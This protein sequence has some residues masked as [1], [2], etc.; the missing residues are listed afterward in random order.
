MWIEVEKDAMAPKPQYFMDLKFYT[1]DMYYLYIKYN[2][3]KLK[4][5][6]IIIILKLFIFNLK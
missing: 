2:K 6:Q 1:Q 4:N 3:L 5:F